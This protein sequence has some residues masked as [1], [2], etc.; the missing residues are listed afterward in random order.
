MSD[1]NTALFIFGLVLI[2]FGLAYPFI[3][4]WR[5]NRQLSG[6]EP[7]VNRQLVITMVL[8]GLVPLMAV[9][10]GFWLMTPRARSSLFFMG[11]LLATGILLI[12]TLMAGWYINRGR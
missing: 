1:S 4:L 12:A 9:L 5:L 11:A 2:V 6:A 8:A 3:V 10:T 7:V